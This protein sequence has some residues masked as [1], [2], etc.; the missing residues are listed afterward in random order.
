MKWLSNPKH[1]PQVGDKRY[2]MKF[3][4]FPIYAWSIKDNLR[5]KVWAQSYK[6]KQ[7]YQETSKIIQ[8]VAVRYYKWVEIENMIA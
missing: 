5:Y 2:V 8:G 7:V 3:A 6:Q 1:D 4:W